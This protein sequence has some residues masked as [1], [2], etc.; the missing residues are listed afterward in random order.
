[1]EP[2]INARLC[3][4]S[5]AGII[6]KPHNK[7]QMNADERRF[8]PAYHVYLNSYAANIP[9]IM[10]GLQKIILLFTQSDTDERRL[11]ELS[12]KIIWAAFEMSDVLKTFKEFAEIHIAQCLNHLEIIGLKLC[13]R[14]NFSKPRV[15]IKRI[16]NGIGNKKSL[17]NSDN[18]LFFQNISAFIC[19]H[20][21]LIFVFLRYSTQKMQLKSFMSRAEKDILFG[22]GF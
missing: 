9:Y 22:A 20:L 14:I 18:C 1:M 10:T 3:E 2:Q 19:V 12:E 8:V 15:E 11:N 7:P 13:L 16:V 17:I 4:N 21:R 5:T 6:T